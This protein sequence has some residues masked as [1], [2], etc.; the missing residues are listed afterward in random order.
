[1]ELLARNDDVAVLVSG[2]VAY[3]AG[4]SLNVVRIHRLAGAGMHGP[5]GRMSPEYNDGL[6]FGIRFSDGSKA[7]D[8]DRFRAVPG[9]TR[10][11]A[12]ESRG[13]GG[14]GRK[15][16]SGYWCSPLPPPGLMTLVCAW[17]RYG[18]DHAEAD[19]DADMVIAAAQRA[20]PIWKDDVGLPEPPPG[21][22][23]GS[24][25]SGYSQR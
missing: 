7:T 8:Q 5:V 10:A 4:F 18:I 25:W 21:P 11:R 2:F 6:R 22:G 14:G 20:T 16:T 15:Y 24:G 17:S 1:V 19:V 13:G 23:G 12:L 9:S 3:P